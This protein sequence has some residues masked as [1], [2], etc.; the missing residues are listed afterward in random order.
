MFS[1]IPLLI[2][3]PVNNIF[4]PA[5]LIEQD[6]EDAD[7][8]MNVYRSLHNLKHATSKTDVKRIKKYK[9]SRGVTDSDSSNSAG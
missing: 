6:A 5:Y 8:I 9:T 4:V 2:Q 3:S 1:V 7:I